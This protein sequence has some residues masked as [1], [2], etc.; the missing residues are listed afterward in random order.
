MIQTDGDGHIVTPW[1]TLSTSAS[2]GLTIISGGYNILTVTV[3]VSN[4]YIMLYQVYLLHQT[5]IKL[6]ILSGDRN[7]LLMYM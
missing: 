1:N 7:W 3:T 6:T 5:G 4:N 2:P